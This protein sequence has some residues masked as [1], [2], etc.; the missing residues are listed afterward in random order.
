M[1]EK[2]YFLI[3]DLK[4][5]AKFKSLDSKDQDALL[6][7]RNE[8]FCVIDIN[9]DDELLDKIIEDCTEEFEKAKS[10]GS[11]RARVASAHLFSESAKSLALNPNI[12][13]LLKTAY[14]REPIPFGTLNFDRGTEQPTHSDSI[15]FNTYPYGFMCGVWVALEDIDENNGPLHYYPGSHK[16]P[17]FGLDQ[18]SMHG[19]VNPPTYEHYPV[20]EKELQRLIESLDLKKESV[21]MRKGDCLIWAANLLHGGDPIHDKSRTRY[22]QVTHYF[23]EDCFYYTPLLSSP[24]TKEF[25]IRRPMNIITGEPISVSDQEKFASNAGVNIKALT[26]NESE[27]SGK[28]KKSFMQRVFG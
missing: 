5:D 11:D 21:T 26:N 20:Y 14:G 8:G 1:L 12:L 27:P 9:V 15:H 16:L 19:S 13:K 24:F 22:S 18:F 23:F 28:E 25:N 6:S 10:D 17:F 7:L 4:D 3:P 2:P